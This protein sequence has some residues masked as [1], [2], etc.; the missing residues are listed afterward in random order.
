MLT[1]HGFFFTFFRGVD[2]TG[3]TKNCN[4]STHTH[5]RTRTTIVNKVFHL[6]WNRKCWFWRREL[7]YPFD[8]SSVLSFKVLPLQI[9]FRQRNLIISLTSWTQECCSCDSMQF[10]WKLKEEKNLFTKL[11]SQNLNQNK[12][13][14]YTTLTK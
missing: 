5:T 9:C 1:I 14:D 2:S 6:L 7:G 10:S 13:S 12:Q 8:D 4:T 3:P 11:C